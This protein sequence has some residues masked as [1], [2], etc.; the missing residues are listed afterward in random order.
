MAGPPE[1]VDHLRGAGIDLP[2]PDPIPYPMHL[3]HSGAP[4]RLWARPAVGRGRT[5]TR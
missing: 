2:G 1:P 4:A 5:E 3:L